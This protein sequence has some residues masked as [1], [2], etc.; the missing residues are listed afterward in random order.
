MAHCYSIGLVDVGEGWG[1]V[2]AELVYTI[3][4]S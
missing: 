1:E 3:L 2:G 4:A